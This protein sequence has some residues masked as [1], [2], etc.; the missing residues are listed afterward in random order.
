MRT[1]IRAAI[2]AMLDA[3]TGSGKVL[4]ACYDA[5]QDLS[6][7]DFGAFPVA[8]IHY[9]RKD[10]DWGDNRD[11]DVMFFFAVAVYVPMD[12]DTID[13]AE[14]KMDAII[15]TLDAYFANHQSLGGVVLGIKPAATEPFRVMNKTKTLY[16]TGIILGCRLLQDTD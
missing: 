12:P 11:W 1:E 9:L 8:E 16:G 13:V 4:A 2:K 6:K 7:T 5:P 15:D 14:K 10:A 3:N